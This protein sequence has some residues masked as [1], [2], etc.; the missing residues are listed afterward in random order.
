MGDSFPEFQIKLKQ[1]AVQKLLKISCE[2]VRNDID[3][4][5]DI[6]ILE[7]T[8]TYLKNEEPNNL[9]SYQEFLKYFGISKKGIS[10]ATTW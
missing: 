3:D 5:N 7:I 9:P 1:W 10:H 8:Q 2:N 6:L 4:I